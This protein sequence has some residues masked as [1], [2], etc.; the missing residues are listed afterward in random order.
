MQTPPAPTP[1]GQVSAP[2]N[3]TAAADRLPWAEAERR[4]RLR[5]LSGEASLE[6]S[7]LG[8]D[9]ET[10]PDPGLSDIVY[11]VIAGYGLLHC[12]ETTLEFTIGD[13]LFLPRGRPHRIERQDAE[14]RLWRI[15]L[16]PPPGPDPAESGPT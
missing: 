9:G 8:L 1:P 6:I 4:L 3:L 10:G 7:A 15:A 11:V 12:A 13:V 14:V 5:A 16:G 2:V